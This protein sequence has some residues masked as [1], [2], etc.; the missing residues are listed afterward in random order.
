MDTRWF[1]IDDVGAVAMLRSGETGAVPS[2]LRPS[3]DP[4]A[5]DDVEYVF[6]FVDTPGARPFVIESDP[7]NQLE[8]Y[9]NE[10]VARLGVYEYSH[11]PRNQNVAQLYTRQFRPLVPIAASALPEAIRQR[12]VR[13]EGIRFEFAPLL[14]PLDFVEGRAWDN[15][16]FLSLRDWA[17][18]D[19]QDG[20]IVGYA[21]EDSDVPLWEIPGALLRWNLG[22]ALRSLDT[23]DPVAAFSCRG[24]DY[25][26]YAREIL[27][28]R[29]ETAL[30]DYDET[31][32]FGERMRAPFTAPLGPPLAL[33]SRETLELLCANSRLPMSWLTEGS[34]R[35]FLCHAQDWLDNAQFE[36]TRDA[37]GAMSLGCLPAELLVSLA[38]DAKATVTAERLAR[39]ER[40]SHIVYWRV[41]TR[42]EIALVQSV[43]GG[44]ASDR[45]RAIFELGFALDPVATDVAA[46]WA[47]VPRPGSL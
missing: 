46:L 9:P 45:E 29:G 22:D 27:R 8:R 25:G 32:S 13:L 28:L 16:P 2:S 15:I 12:A 38:R 39:D 31:A 3:D 35:R 10:F 5:I 43:R 19:W 47:A 30:P 20:G 18:R 26:A 11:E 42:E 33:K 17:L 24:V 6:D 40:R 44:L 14:Q 21:L 23:F 36:D 41:A 1:A 4:D 34:A 7:D 37:H